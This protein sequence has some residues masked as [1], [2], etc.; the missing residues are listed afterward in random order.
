MSVVFYSGAVFVCVGVASRL[1]V[2]NS[3]SSTGGS[4]VR[5]DLSK[6]VTPQI[7]QI[8]KEVMA[9]VIIIFFFFFFFFFFLLTGEICILFK[10]MK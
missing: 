3:L 9:F 2:Y 4:W 1:C 7:L 10:F 5:P 8:N 6:C